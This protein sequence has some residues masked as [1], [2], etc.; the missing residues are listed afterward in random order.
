M[1]KKFIRCSFQLSKQKL[2]ISILI[3][4]PRKD[5][6]SVASNFIIINCNDTNH[7]KRK[8][9]IFSIKQSSGDRLENETEE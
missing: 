9:A 5:Y 8:P 3:E 1:V 7:K 2:R 6:N 4:L